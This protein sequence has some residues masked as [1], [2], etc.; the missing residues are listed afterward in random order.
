MLV[1]HFALV[2]AK[3]MLRHGKWLE[4]GAARGRSPDLE[5]CRRVSVRT[6]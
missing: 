1:R 4:E 3:L 5:E 6:V 2:Q